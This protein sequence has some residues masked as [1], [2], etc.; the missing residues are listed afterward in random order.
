M[1][2][3]IVGKVMSAEAFVSYTREAHQRALEPARDSHTLITAWSSRIRFRKP[4]GDQ[5]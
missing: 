4:V 1:D 2:L 5:R 3:L